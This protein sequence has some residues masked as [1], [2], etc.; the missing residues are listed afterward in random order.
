MEPTSWNE[1]RKVR[2]KAKLKQAIL[3]IARSIAITEGFEA[4]TIRRIASAIEY[5]PPAIY[6][7][8]ENKEAIFNDLI[9]SQFWRLLEIMKN[10]YNLEIEPEARLLRLA[11]SY[12]EFAE[13]CPQM[14]NAMHNMSTAPVGQKPEL[15]SIKY[16]QEIISDVL[17][18]IFKP[19]QLSQEEL[20]DMVQLLRGTIQGLISIGLSGRIQGGNERV[21][22]LIERSVKDYLNAWRQR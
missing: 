12:W 15:E 2:E 5:G 9:N 3:E 8:F 13:N 7:L 1:S 6:A 4:V 21:A 19:R 11:R 20:D 22:A 17:R 16:L 18:D 14:F 10:A